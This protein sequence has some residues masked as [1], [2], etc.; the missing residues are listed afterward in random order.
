MQ[1]LSG[2][3]ST[4]LGE[5]PQNDDSSAHEQQPQSPSNSTSKL[6]KESHSK[7]EET[8]SSAI[9][10]SRPI[11]PQPLSCNYS[12]FDDLL[13]STGPA[14]E[15]VYEGDGPVTQSPEMN[16]AAN[17]NSLAQ[18]LPSIWSFEYQMGTEPYANALAG[19]EDTCITRGR[20]WIET[21]SPFSDHIETLQRLLKGK[22][23]KITPSTGIN[24]T[25][26]V[27]H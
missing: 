25:L 19:T 22:V 3:L 7:G 24:I 21:N 9:Q 11:Y 23:E 12:L 2:N 13:T 20:N 26:C 15:S 8:G 27:G 18:Q 10:V 5:S 14:L 4:A 17:F 16:L 6:S 1:S